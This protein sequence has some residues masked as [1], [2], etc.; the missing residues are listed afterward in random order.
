MELPVCVWDVLHVSLR[1]LLIK[2]SIDQMSFVSSGILLTANAQSRKS[3]LPLSLGP[4]NLEVSTL[5]SNGS[6]LY[7]QRISRDV[8]PVY[9]S[10]ISVG[11]H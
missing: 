6:L 4:S 8:L 5:L 3:D 2:S 9:T 7:N 11:P 1:P 10:F